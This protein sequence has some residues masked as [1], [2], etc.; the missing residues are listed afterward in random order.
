MIT[1]VLILHG[2]LPTAIALKQAMERG[3]RYE[4]HPFTTPDSAVEFI[5]EHPQDAALID[6]SSLGSSAVD[7]I[8]AIRQA[9]PDILI[10]TAPSPGSALVDELGISATL[11]SG[12]RAN[13]VMAAIDGLVERSGN[14]AW[15][16]PVN[17]APEMNRTAML[18]HVFDDSTPP[19]PDTLPEHGSLEAVLQQIGHEDFGFDLGPNESE[20]PDPHSPGADF[21]ALLQG[22]SPGD[23]DRSSRS[24]FNA[25]VDSL[26]RDEPS[27]SRMM[28]FIIRG[29]SESVEEDVEE[30]HRNAER[31]R[32]IKRRYS[33]EA[34]NNYRNLAKAEPPMPSF[35]EGGTVSDLVSGAHD[36]GFEKVLALLRGD[37]VPDAGSDSSQSIK[38]SPSDFN[39]SSTGVIEPPKRHND[40]DFDDVPTADDDSPARAILERTLEQSLSHDEFSLDE[41][42][43]SIEEQFGMKSPQIKP[44]SPHVRAEA[45]RRWREAMTAREGRFMPPQEAEDLPPAPQEVP[46]GFMYDQTTRPSLA[47]HFETRPE[48]METEWL[49]EPVRPRG[50]TMAIREVPGDTPRS[51]ASQRGARQDDLPPEPPP[52]PPESLPESMSQYETPQVHQDF[53]QDFDQ[54]F[55][56]EAEAAEADLAPS[57]AEMFAAMEPAQSLGQA[58]EVADESGWIDLDSEDFNTQFELMAAFELALPSGGQ[59]QGALYTET[60]NERT[61]EE[62]AAMAAVQLTDMALETTAEAVL[63]LRDGEIMAQ[64]G[65]MSGDELL[66]L[67]AAILTATGTQRRDTRVQFITQ[68]ETG[69]DYMLYACRTEDDLTLALIFKGTTSM[70][71]IRRQ[72]GRLVKALAAVPDANALPGLL[73]AA[74]PPAPAR[75]AIPPQTAS[76]PSVTAG[77]S[78]ATTPASPPRPTSVPEVEPRESYSYVWLMRDAEALI[79]APVAQAIS[80][81]MRMQLSEVG[82]QIH[83]LHVSEDFV[84]V[85]GEAPDDTPAFRVVRDL[86]RR[87]AEIARA[88]NS[89]IHPESLWADSY[90][91]VTPGRALDVEEIQQFINFERM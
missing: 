13:D 59:T 5:R 42:L 82:W 40:F 1:A 58:L 43:T 39:Y 16:G 74:S 17:I 80:A 65:R 21:D 8:V 25:L 62:R 32:R 90:L 55:D 78:A 48:Q 68:P 72:G 49:D 79:E 53:D 51:G 24:D 31:A 91:I 19:L 34:V 46:E 89:A 6:F 85:Y 33:Q 44:L 70:S 29:G 36:K 63:L 9:Q 69:R 2:K 20:H 41:L 84:Y 87:S 37:E 22:L 45:E 60:P 52:L 15:S 66:S 47:Q 11:Q 7:A 61:T 38:A 18:E 12:Y 3:T 76:T 30:Q 57:Y 75:T 81:G 4:V 86:K 50:D 35:D 88:Q 23:Q 56:R 73:A 64:A 77:Q 67:Q 10:V 28:D 54:E 71:D 83:D 26:K 14:E 27:R